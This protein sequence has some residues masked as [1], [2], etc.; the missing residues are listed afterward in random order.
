VDDAMTRDEPRQ[1]A[2]R[3]RSR[4]PLQRVYARSMR[5]NPTNAE[6]KLWWHLRRRLAQSGTHFRRQVQIGRYIADFVSHGAKLII[7]ADGGQHVTNVESD[8]ERSKVFEAHGYRVLRYWNND[9][10]ANIDG[11]LED[12]QRALASTPTSDPSPQGGGE[13][14]PTPAARVLQAGGGEP[15][16]SESA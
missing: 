5:G 16:G 6:A 2:I 14:S 1:W 3:D 10:L 15:R 7:E 13:K 8:L 9:V 12:I 4:A 11:V